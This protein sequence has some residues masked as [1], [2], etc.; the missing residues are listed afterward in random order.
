MSMSTLAAPLSTGFTPPERLIRAALG[1]PV[2]LQV[3]LDGSP[4]VEDGPDKLIPVGRPHRAQDLNP[5]VD[6]VLGP[7]V[8]LQRDAAAPREAPLQ[9]GVE[10]VA[11][12][13]SNMR[14][15]NIADDDDLDHDPTLHAHHAERDTIRV[16][17]PAVR[18]P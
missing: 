17:Q 15:D 11:A 14:W 5:A 12:W 18:C 7:P 16:L 10:G 9:R 6:I 1:S 13:C 4:G 3:R 2:R 8:A